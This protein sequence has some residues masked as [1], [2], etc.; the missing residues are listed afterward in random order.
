MQ[1]LTARWLTLKNLPSYK[2]KNLHRMERAVFDYALYCKKTFPKD[3]TTPP[4]WWQCTGSFLGGDIKAV[5]KQSFEALA[6]ANEEV[7]V[8]AKKE[9][10][11]L[12]EVFS[13]INLMHRLDKLALRA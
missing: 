2:I 3:K 6:K 12:R 11:D 10:I 8:N 13:D 9:N 4:L 7:A 1:Y 5:F